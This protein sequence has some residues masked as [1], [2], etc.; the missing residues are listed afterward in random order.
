[1]SYGGSPSCGFDDIDDYGREYTLE[2]KITK[3]E[4][5]LSWFE[6]FYEEA[7]LNNKEKDMRRPEAKKAYKEIKKL[8]KNQDK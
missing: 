4:R 2:K 1:M 3:E 8:I 5:L 6:L 7:K